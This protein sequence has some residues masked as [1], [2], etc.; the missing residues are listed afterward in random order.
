MRWGRRK[1]FEFGAPEAGGKIAVPPNR[2][3]AVVAI[4]G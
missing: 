2:A 4:I 3:R 1:G